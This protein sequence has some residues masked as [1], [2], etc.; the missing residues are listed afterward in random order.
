MRYN[1]NGPVVALDIDGTLGDYHGHFL[2][3]ASAW[4][5]KSM[6]LPDD[7]NPGLPLHRHMRISKARYR[8]CKLAFRQGGLK[9]SMPVYEGA[10]QLTHAIRKTGAELWITTSRPYLR[11][12]NIDPDTR[13]WLRRNG[14]TYDACIY[15]ERKYRDLTRIV[16]ANRVAV[17]MDDLPEMCEQAE[18]VG[19]IAILRDQPYNRHANCRRVM[20]LVEAQHEIL[21]LIT[22]WKK[23]YN[24]NE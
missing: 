10:Q 20:N 2:R 7:I 24:G 9:R 22:K 3:F 6:P 21:H 5:G 18:E 15:G 13:H 8:E 1:H 14:I 12:D 17:V 11:L 23:E 4:T 16:G 19:L